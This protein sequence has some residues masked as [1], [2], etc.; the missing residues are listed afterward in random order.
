MHAQDLHEPKGDTIWTKYQVNQE[1]T[2]KCDK[3]K[4]VQIISK[5]QINTW[6]KIPIETKSNQHII[7]EIPIG[8]RYQMRIRYQMRVRYQLNKSSRK[9]VS[10]SQKRAKGS[11]N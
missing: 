4:V 2:Q 6:F 10:N 5:F 3:I 7:D 11:N 1:G 8:K 9:E